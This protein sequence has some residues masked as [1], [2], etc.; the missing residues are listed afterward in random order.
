MVLTNQVAD[1]IGKSN[2]TTGD[3]VDLGL[4]V[5]NAAINNIGSTGRR[6][7]RAKRKDG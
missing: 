6:E 3:K 5:L 2:V 4:K 7:N 1:L